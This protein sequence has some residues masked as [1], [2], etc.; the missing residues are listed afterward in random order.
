MLPSERSDVFQNLIGFQSIARPYESL[1]AFI[2]RLIRANL[3]NRSEVY[4]IFPRSWLFDAFEAPRTESVLVPSLLEFCDE[5]EDAT[6]KTT[7]TPWEP[8]P[9]LSVV[10]RLRG[11][12]SCF[13]MGY[14]SY[15]FQSDVIQRCPVHQ[16]AL[17]DICPYCGTGLIWP[18]P[19][20]GLR[21]LQCPAGCDLMQG[22]FDGLLSSHLPIEAR[23]AE[24]AIFV[25][26]LQMA[27][28]FLS[29]PFFVRYPPFR[30]D[31]QYK[32]S[33]G[34]TA[35]II[36]AL[37]RV[38]PGVPEL[39]D[40]HR[41]TGSCWEV[42]VRRVARLTPKE[43][44]DEQRNRFMRRF[45]RG[46]F[47]TR[48][49]ILQESSTT[50]RFRS[51][52]K[53]SPIRVRMRGRYPVIDAE[54]YVFLNSELQAL[55]SLLEQRSGSGAACQ[56]VHCLD[57]LLN[58]CGKRYERMLGVLNQWDDADIAEW[59][60]GLARL[61]NVIWRITAVIRTKETAKLDWRDLSNYRFLFFSHYQLLQLDREFSLPGS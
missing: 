6:L 34:L 9:G 1:Y 21:A 46:I 59:F 4:A 19:S 47:N 56:Y 10:D 35:A 49:P 32:R 44:A 23:L 39:K 41:A 54:P 53:E 26:E 30:L 51:A 18:Q 25:K 16:D 28:K 36:E 14:H 3:L 24:H 8:F 48:V 22:P 20:I 29:T 12:R 31:E 57:S 50:R 43:L 15:A 45:Q 60:E 42:R 2:S 40:Y 5:L 13:S 38:A 37:R 33:P 52:P 61:S 11:C 17:T 58:H 7:I 27:C 55:R